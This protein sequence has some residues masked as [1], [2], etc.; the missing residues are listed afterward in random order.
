MCY[1]VWLCIGLGDLNS[2]P[3]DPM[4]NT[5]PTETLPRP[6]VVIIIVFVCLY[7][8]FNDGETGFK[9]GVAP[10]AKMPTIP[11]SSPN[12]QSTSGIM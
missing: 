6:S 12:C 9:E 4:T 10:L 1:H 8:F 7:V 3:H 2:H 11:V 5:L